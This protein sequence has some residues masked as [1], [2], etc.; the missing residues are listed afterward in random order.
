M[1]LFYYNVDFRK[2]KI[3]LHSASAD[4]H[5]AKPIIILA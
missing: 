1:R 3:F 5:S 2:A 4:H